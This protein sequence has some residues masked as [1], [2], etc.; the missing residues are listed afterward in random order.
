M[1]PL[2]A[3]RRRTFPLPNEDAVTIML[4]GSTCRKATFE[5]YLHSIWRGLFLISLRW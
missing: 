5:K 4:G 3:L 1:L 2:A